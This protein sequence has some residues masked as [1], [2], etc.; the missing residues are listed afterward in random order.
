MVITL[1][2]TAIIQNLSKCFKIILL[3]ANGLSRFGTQ[4]WLQ[5]HAEYMAHVKENDFIKNQNLSAF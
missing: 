4:Y 1:V 3:E 5:S 2:P